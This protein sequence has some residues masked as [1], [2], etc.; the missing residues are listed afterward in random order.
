MITCGTG[1]VGN[2]RAVVVV[3]VLSLKGGVGKTSTALGLAAAALHRAWR[4]LVVDLDP[5][6]NAT[7][8]L[9]GLAPA[10]GTAGPDVAEVLA[11]PTREQVE[12]ALVGSRWTSGRAGTPAV[13]GPVVDVLPGSE[14]TARFDDPDPAAGRRNRL[15][16]ALR[17]APGYRLVVVDCPP[18]LG[19]LTRNALAAADR[20]LVV[21][22]PGLFAVQGAD[23]AVRAVSDAVAHN[24]G[25]REAGIV[26][27]RYRERSPEHR[28]RVSELRSLFGER[29]LDPPV[30]ERAAVSRAQEFSVPL[31]ELP[32]EQAAALADRY[33]LLLTQVV[34][35][36][37]DGR[38]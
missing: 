5:Q 34:G 1:A 27:N 21:T 4:T 17:R 6:A 24:P 32:G 13:S 9:T 26:V 18:S 22:E 31:T 12:A 14:R 23:S 7:T 19:R 33:D 30:P 36:R 15:R 37:A 29:V 28:F 16:S 25:L 10:P 35:E 38:G 8:A 3:A 2:V 11:D 20:A